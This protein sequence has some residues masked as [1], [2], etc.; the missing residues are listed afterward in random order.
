MI[1]LMTHVKTFDLVLQTDKNRWLIYTCNS[2]I[3]PA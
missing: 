3:E 2:G 1:S